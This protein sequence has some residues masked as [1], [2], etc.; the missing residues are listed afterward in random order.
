MEISG[1]TLSVFLGMLFLAAAAGADTTPPANCTPHPVMFDNGG[2]PLAVSCPPF[3]VPGA[4]LTGVTLTFE[5]DYQFGGATRTNAVDVTFVPTGPA[6][7]TWSAPSVKLTT[8]GARSSGPAPTGSMNATS[9]I[10]AAS[11]AA[12]FTVKITSEVTVGMVAS[13]SG[14]ASVVYTYTPPPPITLACPAAGGTTG[15]PYSSALVATGGVP[16][17]AF[18]ITSGSLPPGSSLDSTGDIR[19][20]PTTVGTF[21]FTA[22]VVDSTGTAAGTAT[23]RCTIMNTS[24]VI[25]SGWRREPPPPR[26]TGGCPTTAPTVSYY[27]SYATYT[28]PVVTVVSPPGV[29]SVRIVMVSQ[30]PQAVVREYP[31]EV[32]SPGHTPYYIAFTDSSVRLADSYW[33]KDRT[34]YYVT[35][36]HTLEQAPL[37]SL[38]RSLSERL[39]C[40]KNLQFHLPAEL[41]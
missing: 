2:G 10:S 27:R 5:A 7:V 9:G 11:F 40:E 31:Q 22:Q 32:R 25:V 12:P 35:S 18:S 33:V 23:A 15:A 16:P 14:A 28:T 21:N 1:K 24:P 17:Y 38:D 13:S 8:G 6:G 30:V 34:L 37:N 20:T 26:P 36:D 19:G 39:N 41:Q 4:T 29:P 3:A